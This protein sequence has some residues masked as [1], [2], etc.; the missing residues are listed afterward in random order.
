MHNS[1]EVLAPPQGVW[2]IQLRCINPHGR[3]V[4]QALDFAGWS[5]RGVHGEQGVLRADADAAAALLTAARAL[6]S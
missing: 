2:V 5:G 1:P 6:R 3:R 4:G